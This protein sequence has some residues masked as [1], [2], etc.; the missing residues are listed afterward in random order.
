MLVN[1]RDSDM[2]LGAKS[3]IMKGI[4]FLRSFKAIIQLIL[5]TDQFVKPDVS[6]DSDTQIIT[7]SCQLP[8]SCQSRCSRCNRKS[9]MT[10]VVEFVDGVLW[11]LDLLKSLSKPRH[12]SSVQRTWCREV[13]SVP[14]ARYNSRS[15]K[16]FEESK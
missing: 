3:L 9:P 1:T 16:N 6:F 12:T 5:G 11:I 2:I 13:C 15:V 10:A 7:V 4:S 14:W 8:K